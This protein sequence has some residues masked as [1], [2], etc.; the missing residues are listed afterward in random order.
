MIPDIYLSDEQVNKIHLGYFP[1]LYNGRHA[2][3]K[4]A[5]DNA[6]KQV[7]EWIET[8]EM[9]EVAEEKDKD[10]YEAYLIPVGSLQKLAGGK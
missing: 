2:I 1:H 9:T 6:V 10:N 3:A 8:C 5:A 4:A 7:V